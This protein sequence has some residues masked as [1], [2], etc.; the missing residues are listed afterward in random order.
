VRFNAFAIFANGSLRAMA[1]RVRMS[2]VDQDRLE[3]AFFVFVFAFVFVVA[4]VIM[5]VL[6]LPA[7]RSIAST[8]F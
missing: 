2:S 3:V 7:A 8:L 4:F 5:V 6:S 1:L